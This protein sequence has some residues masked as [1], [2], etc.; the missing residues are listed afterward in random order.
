MFRL[1]GAI[2]SAKKMYGMKGIYRTMYQKLAQAAALLVLFAFVSGCATPINSAQRQ[3]LRE[4]KAEGIAVE[5]KSPAAAAAL[6]I[7]P[8]GGSFYTRN[9]GIGV[10][11]LL[12]WP[13][14]ILWDPVSGYQG[15]QAI[16]YYASKHNAE[17]IREEKLGMLEDR[18][19]LDEISRREYVR[20][21]REIRNKY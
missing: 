6:G 5:E 4:Y 10:V 15:A 20:K 8:G 2:P 3:E 18:Y 14:S 9:Y 13:A 19:A 11:N 21:R 1:S 12:F 17:T 7:L 16:N